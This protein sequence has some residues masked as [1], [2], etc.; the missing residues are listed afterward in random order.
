MASLLYIRASPR[1]E[2]SHSLAV[3]D[4][5]VEAY[6]AAHPGDT[7]KT[8]DAQAQQIAKSF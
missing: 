8:L 3:A 6:R 2:R 5:F 4:A 1:G 7:V